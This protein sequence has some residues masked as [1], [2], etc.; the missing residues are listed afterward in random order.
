M[1]V[2]T[3][4]REENHFPPYWDYIYD[5]KLQKSGRTSTDNQYGYRSNTQI[6]EGTTVNARAVFEYPKWNLV[7]SRPL[8]DEDA[9]VFLSL[10]FALFVVYFQAFVGVRSIQFLM[11]YLTHF[12]WLMGVN[13]MWTTESTP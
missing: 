3:E 11:F 1:Q 6:A 4:I 5:Q 13:A 12:V 8:C 10:Q 7:P 9:C 2:Y